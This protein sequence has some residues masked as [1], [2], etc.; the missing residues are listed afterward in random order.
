VI[1]HIGE[2][3]WAIN[4]RN[5]SLD[6][7][8]AYIRQY[9]GNFFE[10]LP[11]RCR[12]DLPEHLPPQTLT[13]EARR[14]LFLVTKEA[15]NNILK[16]A[17]AKEVQIKMAL[18]GDD[19]E[20]SIEDNGKGFCQQEVSRFGNGLKNMKKRMA[21]IGGQFEISSRP[22]EGTVIKIRLRLVR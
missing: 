10:A 17:E 19:L 13:S 4:P 3:I 21:D 1:D 16:H 20:L 18:H 22:G 2:I 6:N 8:I 11:I 7:L 14:N 15:L 9:A 5:D 12:Y